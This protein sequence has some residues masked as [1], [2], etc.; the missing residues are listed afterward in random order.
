VFDKIFHLLLA[1]GVI[2]TLGLMLYAGDP[3]HVTWWAS[4]AVIGAWMVAPYMV[5]SRMSRRLWKSSGAGFVLVLAAT[6]V[7]TSTAAVLWHAYFV[8]PDSHSRQ[9]LL[10]VPIWQSVLWVACLGVARSVR[11]RRGVGN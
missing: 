5:V 1:I 11:L 9:V 3:S 10:F 8:N 7:V 4:F 2:G 6:G